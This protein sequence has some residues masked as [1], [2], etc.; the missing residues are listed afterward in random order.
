M[1]FLK[2]TLDIGIVI[3]VFYWGVQLV[4]RFVA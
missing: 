2:D 4:D 1:S 3:A